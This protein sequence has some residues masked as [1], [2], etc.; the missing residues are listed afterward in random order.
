MTDNA[1]QSQPQPPSQS[2]PSPSP[3]Q[4]NPVLGDMLAHEPAPI[5]EAMR[6]PAYLD[7]THPNHTALVERVYN[8]RA[9]LQSETQSGRVEGFGPGPDA[10]PLD[11]PNSGLGQA[12]FPSEVPAVVQQVWSTLATDIGLGGR[13]LSGLAKAAVPYLS[14]NRRYTYEQGAATLREQ[15][16]DRAEAALRDAK[17][18]IKEYPALLRVLEVR[19]LASH[20]GVIRVLAERF[21]VRETLRARLADIQRDPEYFQLHGEHDHARHQQLAEEA[22]LIQEALH[23]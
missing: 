15:L 23:G 20:P 21:Q 8:M 19:G 13:E 2:Q 18:L 7:V 10:V 12:A 9:A 11:A 17:A 1:S 4:Y 16:G 22:R 5:R 14:D 6:D 3:R